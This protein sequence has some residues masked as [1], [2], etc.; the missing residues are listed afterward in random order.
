MAARPELRSAFVSLTVAEQFAERHIRDP[1]DRE[2]FVRR[3]KA[4]MVASAR[5]VGSKPAQPPEERDLPAR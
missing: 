1:R 3:V 2:L 4:V 5:K